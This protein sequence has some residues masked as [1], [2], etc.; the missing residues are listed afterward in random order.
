[1][2]HPRLKLFLDRGLNLFL[3]HLELLLCDESIIPF[4]YLF[5]DFFDLGPA[6]V[7]SY[8]E[9]LI[10]TNHHWFIAV[11]NSAELVCVL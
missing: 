3:M 9:V 10:G 8:T 7:D 1:M 2:F 6:K 5:A 4:D 11:F